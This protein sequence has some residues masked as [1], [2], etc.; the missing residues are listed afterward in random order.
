M[1]KK[2]AIGAGICILI[3]C[4]TYVLIHFNLY[5]GNKVQENNETYINGTKVEDYIENPARE[6][7]EESGIIVEEATVHENN[8]THIE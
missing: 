6:E 5:R 1:K 8:Q 4:V 3:C 7:M 2:T